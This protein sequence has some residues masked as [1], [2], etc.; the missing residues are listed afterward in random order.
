MRIT[1]NPTSDARSNRGIGNKGFGD[2]PK[3]CHLYDKPRKTTTGTYIYRNGEWTQ[4]DGQVEKDVP[5]REDYEL[6][7]SLDKT[8]SD[9]RKF[10]DPRDRKRISDEYYG[11][12]EEYR[13]RKEVRDYA[14]EAFKME[15]E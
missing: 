13:R 11:K 15:E 10:K 5:I 14:R 1:K 2:H 8:L 6:C 3:A 12:Q 7:R 4:V 9:Y